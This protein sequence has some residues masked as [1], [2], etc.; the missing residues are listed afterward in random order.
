MV[1]EKPNPTTR[2]E[3]DEILQQ[4]YL[5]ALSSFEG[6][7]LSQ[8][9]LKNKLGNRLN[10]T[11]RAGLL[12][13]GGIALS[14]LGL[15]LTLSNQ[16]NSITE[17]VADMN[18]NF[19]SVADRM[20]TIKEHMISMEQQVAL[21]DVIQRETGIMDAE[22]A[23]IT[24]DMEIMR[25]SVDG[26]SNYLDLVR[27]QVG[28]VAISINQMNAEVQAMSHDVHRIGKPARTMNKMFPF[29]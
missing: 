6:I 7:I 26:I 4:Q 3:E 10:Y 23:R 16:I 1:D 11:I 8:I 18:V 21:L 19:I 28:N 15:L 14:I 29:P 24:S 22:M 5:R 25:T 12:I 17:V 13:L 27:T 2:A 20:K 9:D